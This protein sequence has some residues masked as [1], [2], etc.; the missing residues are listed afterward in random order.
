MKLKKFVSKLLGL[1]YI[2]LLDLDYLVFSSHKSGTQTM[3]ATLNGSG[4]NCR[5]CH[6][7]HNFDL[8]SG[9]F[10][11][12]L[13]TFLKYNHKKLNVVTVFRDP[14]ERHISSFFQYYGTRPLKRKEVENETETI[15]YQYTIKQLQE[16]FISELRDKSLHGFTD[17]LHTILQELSISAND[18]I[19]DQERS[20]GF[21]ET[22]IIRLFFFRFDILF[23]NFEYL[24][25]QMAQTNIAQK[26]TNISQ[27]KWYFQVYSE[28]KESLVV[29]KDIIMEV[30]NL[31][32][33][34]ISLFYNGN[35]ERVLSQAY[36]KYGEE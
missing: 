1:K 29:P 27:S 31:K 30:Y 24:V 15:I 26:N 23:S 34:L 17:S 28:F 13:K 33:D 22:E 35:Y 18:L 4:F 3:Q 8:K 12:Y 21:Y 2:E 7:L 6:F 36:T 14:M 19:Y 25:S 10:S 16:K 20:F 5:H 9:D 32:H 11:Q